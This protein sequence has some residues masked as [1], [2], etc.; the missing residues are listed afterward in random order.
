MNPFRRHTLKEQL[1]QVLIQRG[2]ITPEQLSQAL[3]A[4]KEQGGLLGELLTKLGLASEEDIVQALALQLDFPYLPLANYEI[5]LEVLKLIPRDL[6][7]KYHIL[8]VDKMGDI[9]TIVIANP[10][11]NKAI[12]EVEALTKCKAEIFIATYT[13][14]KQAIER[15]YTQKQSSPEGQERGTQ[16][17]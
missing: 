12:E 7:R 16:N 9:L 10:L 14:I 11:N 13:E 15:C 4:Q 6:A 2:V 8:P 1:G 5:D 3:A 17:A